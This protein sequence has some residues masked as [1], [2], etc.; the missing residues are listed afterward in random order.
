ESTEHRHYRRDVGNQRELCVGTR[1]LRHNRVDR[2][3]APERVKPTERRSHI[4]QHFEDFKPDI[5]HGICTF[6]KVAREEEDVGCIASVLGGEPHGIEEG[7]TIRI[8]NDD[9][10]VT[11]RIKVLL[12]IRPW[13][14]HYA[15]A[16]I[17]TK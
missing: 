13:T 3:L 17:L 15:I 12:C 8:V 1:R 6:G 11:G 2:S 16:V 4:R 7:G 14:S 10:I 5:L 9:N